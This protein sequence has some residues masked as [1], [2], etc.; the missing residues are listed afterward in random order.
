L[1]FY[2]LNSDLIVKNI[3]LILHTIFFLF[4]QFTSGKQS[5]TVCGHTVSSRKE[6]EPIGLLGPRSFLTNQSSLLVSIHTDREEALWNEV[7]TV[8]LVITAYRG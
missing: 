4:L 7:N 6:S 3:H 1:S 2:S 8:Q 5:S